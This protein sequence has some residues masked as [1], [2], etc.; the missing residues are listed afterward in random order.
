MPLI[1]NING[2]T[3][4]VYLHSDTMGAD[5]HPIDIYK[6]MRTLR[7]NSESLRKYDLFMKADGN[8][9]KTAST[10][11][12]RF[13]TLLDGT[14]II[15]YDSSHEITIT[16][17]II[18]D[19]GQSGIDC[20]DRS[21][22]DPATVVDINYVPP[23][24]EIITVAGGSGLDQEEHDEL[25]GITNDVW[26]ETLADHT[27]DGTYG[28]E[29][30]T[31]AD[32]AAASSTTETIALT[33]SVI[34]GIQ[35]SGTFASTAIRDNAYWEIEEHGDNGLTAE[36]T[37]NIPDDD[38]AGVFRVFGRYEGTP[39]LLHYMELWTYN[40]EAS[41][42]EKLLEN[43][44]PGGNTSDEEYEHEYFERNIDRT[45]NSEVKFRLIHNV[46][47]YNVNHHMYLD[48]AEVT[49]IE[50]ITAADIATAVWAEDEAK[51]VLGLLDENSYLDNQTYDSNDQLLT[52]RK[53]IYSV[54][55]SVGTDNNVIGTYNITATWSGA[56]ITSY[57]MVII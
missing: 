46:T 14:R 4:R 10:S 57:K 49:S 51:R 21:T 1:D 43:F 22:L 13:V 48:F 7:K 5:V 52:A 17:T 44:L 40:Y 41:A 25:M 29:L 32:I 2:T 37:F 27:T 42:W 45:N 19:G 11:T 54:A 8:V 34:Y 9:T 55:G 20:F 23:Q 50:V 38:R 12:E 53:R 31:K 28:G 16:G 56:Q 33:G 15:P 35:D 18:T 6:E 39:A 3:R 30:A 47:S 24:V 36:L 26:E